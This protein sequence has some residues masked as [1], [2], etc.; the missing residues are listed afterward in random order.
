MVLTNYYTVKHQAE[1]ELV[2]KK[3]R[4][5]AQVAPVIST[6]EAEDF[7]LSIREK[8]KEATHNVYAYL[9]GDKGLCQKASDDGEPS[10]TAGKPILEL[11]KNKTLQDVVIVVTRY[12]GGKLLGA[13]G[14][15]RAYGQCASQGICA[16]VEIEKV[17]HR[18]LRIVIDYSQFG[19]LQRK[20]EDLELT[21]DGIDYTDM[22]TI[23]VLVKFAEAEKLKEMFIN[24]TNGQ[25]IVEE[26]ETKYLDFIR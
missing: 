19:V 15:I 21:L 11:I 2:I 24:M 22:V 9:L 8:H 12:F 25:A 16:A 5:I 13:G 10:G 14:L 23:N 3:S 17:L 1:S 7:I 18:H 26:L 20:I 4:F 6:D